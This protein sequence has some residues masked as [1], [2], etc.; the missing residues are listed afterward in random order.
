[1]IYTNKRIKHSDLFSH[2]EFIKCFMITQ[3]MIIMYGGFLEGWVKDKIDLDLA[4]WFGGGDGAEVI[5]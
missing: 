2:L 1:M 4:I 3:Y 5:D